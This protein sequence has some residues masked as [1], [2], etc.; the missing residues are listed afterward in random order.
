MGLIIALLGRRNGSSGN[1]QAWTRSWLNLCRQQHCES[2]WAPSGKMIRK[3]TDSLR[4]SY[5]GVIEVYNMQLTELPMDP[6]TGPAPYAALSY[7]W[8]TTRTFP[9]R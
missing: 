5:F 8:G 2:C 4:H 3:F 6:K 9:L 1:M 7:V